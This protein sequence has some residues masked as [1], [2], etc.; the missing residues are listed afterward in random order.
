[1]T[2]EIKRE[3]NNDYIK[4]AY[5]EGVEISSIENKYF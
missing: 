5:S 3:F 2:R 4:V 1:M